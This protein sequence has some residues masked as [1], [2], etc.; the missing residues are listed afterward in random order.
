MN[1]L[2][3]PHSLTELSATVSNTTL[4]SNDERLMTSRTSVVAVCCSNASLRSSVRWRNSLS[5][6]AFSIA[7]TAWSANVVVSFDLLVGKRTDILASHEED[8][9]QFVPL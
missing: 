5:R 2:L 7:I 6:R 4:R 3:A 9:D 8:T 1:A